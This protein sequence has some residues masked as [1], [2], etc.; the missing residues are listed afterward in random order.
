MLLL[1]ILAVCLL[2]LLLF[3]LGYLFLIFPGRRRE[4]SDALIHLPYAHRGLHG[5]GCAENSLSAFAAA[6][7]RGYGIELDVRLSR[8][9]ELVV[10]HDAETD[11]VTGVHGIVSEMSAMELASLSL[12]GTGEGVPT[13]REVLSLVDGR[14]PLLIEIKEDPPSHAVSD[15]TAELLSRY[16]G[17]YL[18]ES[19]NPLSLSRMRRLLPAV[20]RGQLA[21]RLTR[22]R[23]YRRPIYLI[24]ELFLCNR[25]ARPDFIAYRLDEVGFFPL[26]LLRR[27][28]PRP[29][30]AYTVRSEEEERDARAAG[31]DS[32]IFEGY[33]PTLSQRGRT[34]GTAEKGNEK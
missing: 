23:E 11:R 27:L 25:L 18:I 29:L 12:C 4:M 16:S 31:F 34:D 20:R 8:D 7:E 15:R 19:F 33:L 5:T 17:E 10:F 26:R 6:V 9:G 2:V 21:D 32:V 30:L 13:L 28:Y 3:F 14:V 22:E 24:L 1:K